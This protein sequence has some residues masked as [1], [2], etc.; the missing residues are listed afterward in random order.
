MT[1]QVLQV[2]QAA[3]PDVQQGQDQQ[4]EA[5]GAVITVQRRARRAQAAWQCEP[6]QIPLEQ[7]EA[8]V[9]RDLLGRE[10]DRQILLDYLRQGA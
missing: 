2:L 1:H 4:G 10:L 3:G 6:P 7:L 5:R 8:T 9:E